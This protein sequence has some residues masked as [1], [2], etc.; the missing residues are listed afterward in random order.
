ME[1]LGNAYNRNFDLVEYGIMKIVIEMLKIV[2]HQLLTR[3]IK[4]M[5]LALTSIFKKFSIFCLIFI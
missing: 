4:C 3:K 2:P 5:V 1:I